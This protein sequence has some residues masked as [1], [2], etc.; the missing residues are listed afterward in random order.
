MILALGVN[1]NINTR[2]KANIN[3][4]D[5]AMADNINES[6]LLSVKKMIGDHPDNDSFDSDIITHINSVFMILRQLGVGPEKGFTIIDKMAKW[7]DFIPA[8]DTNYESVKTY[9]YV[10]VRLLFDPPMNS[11]VTE[12]LKAMANEFEWRLKEEADLNKK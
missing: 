11:V 5:N 3:G 4:G 7:T 10:K 6:I 12:T 9:M 8:E 2:I 1:N